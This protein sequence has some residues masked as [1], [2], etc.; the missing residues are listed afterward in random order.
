MS[1]SS[2]TIA[3]AISALT[4]TGVTVKDITAIQEQVEPRDCPV[5]FPSPD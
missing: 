3:T 1:F 4:I 5:L 2:T